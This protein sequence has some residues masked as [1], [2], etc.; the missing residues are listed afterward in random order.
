LTSLLQ[1]PEVTAP[2]IG[3]TRRQHLEDATAA[4]DVSLGDD[5]GPALEQD[6]IHHPISGHR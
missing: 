5:E 2:I 6:Y 4:L 3:A 1:K